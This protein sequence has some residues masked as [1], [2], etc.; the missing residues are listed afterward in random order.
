MR[1]LRW[2]DGVI[3]CPVCGDTAHYYLAT[4]RRWKCKSC[5]KQF[6][7]KVG[8][9]FE[10]SPLGLDKWLIAVWLI[11][12]AK[13]GISS[14]E[15]HR[16]LGVTQ[17]TAWF[18]L[19]RIRLAM[20]NGSMILS[21]DV[22]ADESYI[23][24]KARNMHKGKRGKV[25]T[26]GSTGKVAVM[27]ML[28]RGGKVV[29]QVINAPTRQT[30]KDHIMGTVDQTSTLYTDGHSGYDGMSFYHQ[31]HTIDHAV[32]YVRGQCPP[33]SVSTRPRP[34]HFS[35]NRHGTEHAVP[36]PLHCGHCTSSSRSFGLIF[37]CFLA[38]INAPSIYIFD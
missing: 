11:T 34:S 30:I 35:Q 23:G 18:M 5:S 12:N 7:V 28:E 22:E 32:E 9:I 3:G 27:G 25:G 31:H 29:T 1:D 14:Y 2:P 38:R 26:G 15:I 37:I 36:A 8:T 19:H 20:Q 16:A 17:K 21:G 10:D 4:Q 13:N 33:S 24:G 6:S